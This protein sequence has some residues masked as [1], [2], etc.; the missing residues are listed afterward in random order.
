M[1]TKILPTMEDM[2]L[3]IVADTL[4]QFDTMQQLVTTILSHRIFNAAF[5][6]NLRSVSQGIIMKQIPERVLPFSQRQHQQ[7]GTPRL[8]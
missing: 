6:D 7:R 4:V 8:R 1:A 2:P 3:Y 5:K